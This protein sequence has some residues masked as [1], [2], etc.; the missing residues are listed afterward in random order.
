MQSIQLALFVGGCTRRSEESADFEAFN[1]LLRDLIDRFHDDGFFCRHLN[2]L[3]VML[4][5]L[6]KGLLG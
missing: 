1:R 2:G 4:V 6:E 5:P 3:A